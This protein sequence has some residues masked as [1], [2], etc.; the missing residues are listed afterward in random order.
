MARHSK[1]GILQTAG[2][3]VKDGMTFNVIF[4]FDVIKDGKAE[5]EMQSMMKALE[6]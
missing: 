6:W 1:T 2:R 3:G 5:T 4:N